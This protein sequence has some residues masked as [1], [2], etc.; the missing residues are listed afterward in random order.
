MK[1]ISPGPTLLAVVL[2]SLLVSGSV[3]AQTVQPAAAGRPADEVAWWDA[4]WACRRTV[5]VEPGATLS[6]TAAIELPTLGRV[7]PD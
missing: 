5:T 1:R 6:R 4:A 3:R 7:R 2:L